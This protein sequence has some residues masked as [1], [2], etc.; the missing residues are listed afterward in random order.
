MYRRIPFIIFPIVGA[1]V[2]LIILLAIALGLLGLNL[3]HILTSKG[4]I[5]VYI[6]VGLAASVVLARYLFDKDSR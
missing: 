3:W 4:A 2:I 5:L 6:I 1:L